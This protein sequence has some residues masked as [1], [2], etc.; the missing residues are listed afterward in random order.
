M[1]YIFTC[2]RIYAKLGLWTDDIINHIVGR[3]LDQ[4]AIENQLFIR[5]GE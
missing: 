1:H 5:W 2:W 4:F 3:I